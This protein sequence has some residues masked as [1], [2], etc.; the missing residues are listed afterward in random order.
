MFEDSVSNWDINK[1]L[2]L[3]WCKFYYD[4]RELTGKEKPNPD[5]INN[6]Y[7]LDKHLDYI[8]QQREKKEFDNKF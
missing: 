5:I 8:V 7:E 6:D 3:S 2:F 1:T 4:L